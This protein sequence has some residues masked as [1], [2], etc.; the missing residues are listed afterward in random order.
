MPSTLTSS[1][2]VTPRSSAT[3]PNI[4]GGGIG[5][6]TVPPQGGTFPYG[7]I[8]NSSGQV[9]KSDGKSLV[10][11]ISNPFPLIVFIYSR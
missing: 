1:Q 3:E 5:T 10:A 7:D 11:V 4:S 9:I 6:V 8:L 2:Y